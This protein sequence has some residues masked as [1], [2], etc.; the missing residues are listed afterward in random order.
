MLALAGDLSEAVRGEEIGEALE[1]WA[2]RPQRG[3]GF[4]ERLANAHA[5]LPA[6][7]PVVQIGMDTP[8]VRPEDLRA[9]AVALRDH[10][11]VLGPAEDGGWWVLGL[12]DPSAATLLRDVSMS[13]PT[14]YDETRAALIGGGL[15]VGTARTMRDV[16]DAADARAVAGLAAAGEF[17]R[18]W[19]A[20]AP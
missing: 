9:V 4:A 8:Q 12:R 7:P 10:E 16:D 14:T 5:D 6:G 2:V 1:G 13:A 19:R 15:T 3:P 18:T 17:A 11:A 20:V